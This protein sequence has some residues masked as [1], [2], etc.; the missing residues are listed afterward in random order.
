MDPLTV[1]ALVAGGAGLLSSTVGSIFNVGSTQEANE[2]NLQ[3]ARENRDFYYQQWK[4]ENAYNDPSRMMERLSRAGLNPNLMYGDGASGLPPAASMPSV[5]NARVSAPQMDPLAMAQAANLA[6]DTLLKKSQ[7]AKT[8]SDIDVNRGQIKVS[9]SVVMYNNAL[10]N[11]TK[12]QQDNLIAQ[13]KALS[14]ATEEANSRI[15]LNYATIQNMKENT[16]LHSVE[17]SLK[18]K[19]VDALCDKYEAETGW[20]REQIKYAGILAMAQVRN[21]NADAALKRAGVE[22]TQEQKKQVRV[23]TANL[24]VENKQLR[25]NLNQD[26]KYGDADRRL[27]Q[28]QAISEITKSIIGSNPWELI[29]SHF[30]EE[31]FNSGLEH[32]GIE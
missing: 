19:E 18:S 10:S 5:E 1:S 26:M 24:T 31:M 9:E 23:A 8:E 32:Y 11:M 20:T 25:W 4:R 27:K 22:L 21:L 13:T 28:A 12:H 16:Y 7:A 30:K 14:T 29:N 15:A 2:T 17:V 3:I 6:A